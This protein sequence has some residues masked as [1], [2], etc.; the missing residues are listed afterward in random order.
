MAQETRV[1][2]PKDLQPINSLEEYKLL[3]G[4]KGLE[5]AR[6]MKPEELIAE[7]R[8]SGLRGRGGAGFPTAIK[9]ETVYS[10]PSAVKYVVC[11]GA[12][13]EPG[14]Y[15]DRYLISKNPYLVLEG[16]LISAHAVEAKQAIIGI[17]ERF[18]YP[19]KRLREALAEMEADKILQSGYIEIV[20]G[21]DDYLFGEEKA[22]LEVID[23][24]DP[25]PRMYPPYM[26]G[27]KASPTS[28]NPTV[29]NNAESMSHLPNI[30]SKGVDHYRLNGTDDTPGT[31]IMTV[32]GDV[33]RPGMYE[34]SL[35]MT[36]RELLF[37][38]A[39]GPKDKPIKAVFSGVANCVVMPDIFDTPLDFGSMREVGV[40]LG[41]GGFIVYDE[42]R[43]MLDICWM[44]SKFLAE[45][46]C[47]Q[48]LPCNMGCRLITE[49]LTNIR[50][51]NGTKEDIEEIQAELGRCT[52]QT[53]CFLPV[54]ET[55]VVSSIMDK[56]PQEFD[57]SF[58]PS[59]YNRKLVLPKIEHFD[60]ELKDFTYQTKSLSGV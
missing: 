55:K 18:T 42:S 51:G 23:G 39:G 1:L 13:G 17:K 21:P 36:L 34:I 40:G 52:N 15:K 20:L 29:V 12:E 37:D 30:L 47:G 6:R 26:V 50:N 25:M 59:S 2:L 48:C 38:L 19:V 5:R 49:H 35:G 9:W 3:G 53:R 24:R 7:V 8:A 57:L 33:K 43:W 60:E 41:S 56:F 45:S 32:S 11:N 46:S 4:L 16:M 14:T 28:V 31:M 10:D 58:D 22:L 27:V 54:Q 44:F